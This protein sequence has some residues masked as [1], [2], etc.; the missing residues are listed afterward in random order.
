MVDK[1][2]KERAK[3]LRPSKAQILNQIDYYLRSATTDVYLVQESI[4]QIRRSIT[5][6]IANDTKMNVISFEVRK[7]KGEKELILYCPFNIEIHINKFMFE[8]MMKEWGEK[9]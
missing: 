5:K 7:R 1:E 2:V 6:L 4:K 9:E 8:R 3:L